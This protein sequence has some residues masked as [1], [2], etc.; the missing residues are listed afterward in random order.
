M[1]RRLSALGWL[2][3]PLLVLITLK[4]YS[5]Q[6]PIPAARA[7]KL[8]PFA[9]NLSLL[10]S[11]GVSLLKPPSAIERLARLKDPNL[12]PHAVAY[13]RK[14][15]QVWCVFFFVNGGLAL[16]TAL[17]MSDAA[18]ALYNGLLSY[19]AMGCLFAVEWIIRQKVKRRDA[20]A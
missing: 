10:V 17:W 4:R 11:F 9:V 3:L 5:A 13:T 19:L 20:S 1:G 18:W 8:Y 6:I 15:T 7:I 2:L 14:V 16:A 12:S